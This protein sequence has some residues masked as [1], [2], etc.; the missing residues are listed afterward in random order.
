M[1]YEFTVVIERDE[2]GVYIV[3]APAIPGCNTAGDT[4][5]EADKAGATSHET[6]RWPLD[7]NPF[8]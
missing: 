2:D 6:R 7:D 8:S 5:E 4:E 3:T 1:Q